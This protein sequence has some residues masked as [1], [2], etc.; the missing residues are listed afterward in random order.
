MGN[1]S[2]A[3]TSDSARRLRNV[4]PARQDAQ[5]VQTK[6]GLHCKTAERVQGA[7]ATTTDPM[8]KRET[9]STTT[10]TTTTTTRTRTRTRTTRMT[11][12]RT[13]RTAAAA[14]KRR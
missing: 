1:V 11:T 14:T 9:N 2:F 13:T 8:E 7:Y 10:R 3:K 4:R 12:T 6:S 5:D